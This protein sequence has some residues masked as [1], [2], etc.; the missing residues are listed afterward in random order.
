MNIPA[1]SGCRRE[2]CPVWPWLLGWWFIAL[3]AAAFVVW[4]HRGKDD[5]PH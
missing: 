3:F 1:G 5:D 2:T 4:G